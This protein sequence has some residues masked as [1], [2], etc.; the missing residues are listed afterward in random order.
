MIWP[1]ENLL[2]LWKS[3]K[4]PV[5]KTENQLKYFM[6]PA[7]H[8]YFKCVLFCVCLLLFGYG[9]MVLL[10]ICNAISLNYI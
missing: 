5:T 6:P 4:L 8:H 1:V 10:C 3:V 9:I 7:T 2:Q